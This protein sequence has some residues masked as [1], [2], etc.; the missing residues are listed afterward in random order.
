[1]FD[2]SKPKGR[3][4]MLESLRTGL[5]DKDGFVWV[6]PIRM[7]SGD[8]LQIQ[9]DADAQPRSLLVTC[10]GPVTVQANPTTIRAWLA[11]YPDRFAR[12]NA[13]KAAR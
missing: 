13:R 12:R 5:P 6:Q 11:L 1:M 7:Q 9:A 4:A 8:T 3:E 10:D 2:A